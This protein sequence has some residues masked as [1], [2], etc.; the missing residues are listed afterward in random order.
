MEKIYKI[1]YCSCI[2][3]NIKFFWCVFMEGGGGGVFLVLSFVISY[4]FFDINEDGMLISICIFF[5]I[6]KYD[7]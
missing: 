7:I 3:Y 5:I 1:E 6:L 4:Y 2:I